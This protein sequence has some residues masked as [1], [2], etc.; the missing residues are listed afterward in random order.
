MEWSDDFNGDETN[1]TSA[2]IEHL[3]DQIANSPNNNCIESTLDWYKDVTIRQKYDGVA[4]VTQINFSDGRV[5]REGSDG[6]WHKVNADGTLSE[7]GNPYQGLLFSSL[8]VSE[9]EV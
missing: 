4:T 9:T 8:F 3:E 6:L 2:T 7:Y 5:F 1:L